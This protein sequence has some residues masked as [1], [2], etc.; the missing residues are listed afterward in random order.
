[1]FLT[2]HFDAGKHNQLHPAGE[3]YWLSVGAQASDPVQSLLFK[4]D[5]LPPP[6]MVATRRNDPMT[7]RCFDAEKKP[8]VMDNK[9]NEEDIAEDDSLD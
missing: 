2:S 5:L 9:P 7:G 1:M 3:R 4:S 6:P 8:A